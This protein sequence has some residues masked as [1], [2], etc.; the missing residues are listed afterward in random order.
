MTTLVCP[1]C[2]HENEPERIYCHNCGTRLERNAVIKDRAAE[3]AQAAES[4]RHLRKMFQSGRGREKRLLLRFCKLLLG[5]LCLAVIVQMMLPPDLPPP[6]TRVEVAPMI[7]MDIATALSV[8]RPPQLIYNEEQV[9]GYLAASVRRS[10]RDE[11]KSFFPLR[12]LFV[13][14]EEGLCRIHLEQKVFGLSIYSGTFYR[15]AIDAGK[16]VTANSGGYIGRMPIH[17]VLMKYADII[18]HRAWQT[19][20]RERNAIARLVGIEFHP[21]SVTLII[22]R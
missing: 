19:L 10:N 1:D 18:F 15:I 22:A 17:P 21:Q 14:F 5:A 12:H 20:A 13:R 8:H 4:Q 11:N 7:N 16:I 6:V 9:N 3:E 2:R